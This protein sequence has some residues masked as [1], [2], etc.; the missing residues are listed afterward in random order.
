MEVGITGG[1]ETIQDG[2]FIDFSSVIALIVD[3]LDAFRLEGFLPAFYFIS[4]LASSYKFG[5]DVA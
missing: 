4:D 1:V 3:L 2:E 5:T